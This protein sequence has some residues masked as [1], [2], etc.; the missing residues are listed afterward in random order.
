MDRRS[1]LLSGAAVLAAPFIQTSPARAQAT[2]IRRDVTRLSTSDP[3]FTQYAEAV[4]AMHDLPQ[5][6]PRSWFSQAMIHLDHCPHGSQGF[7]PWHRVY[8]LNFE[9]ICADLIGNPDFA[10]PYW[11]WA[12]NSGRLPG[13]FFGGTNLDVGFWGDDGSQVGT[14]ATSALTPTFGLHDHPAVGSIFFQ[15]QIDL[16]KTQTDFTLFWRQLEGNQHNTVHGVVGA[17][18]GHMGSFLSPLDPCFWLHHCNVD[19]IWAEWQAAGNV[20]PTIGEN[21]VGQF[22]DGAGNSAEFLAD[23]YVPLADLD[24][25]YDSIQLPDILSPFLNE[26]T[27]EALNNLLRQ[28]IRPIGVGEAPAEAVLPNVETSVEVRSAGILDELFAQRFFRPA[29]IFSTQRV[30]VGQRRILARFRD[31]RPTSA[32]NGMI[33]KVFVNCPYLSPVID[34]TDRNYAGAFGFFAVGGSEH[35][36]HHGGDGS[37]FVVDIT[38]PLR[39]QAANGRLDPSGI[40]VQL[41]PAISEIGS[42][43]ASFT[44]SS[45]ELLST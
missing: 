9:A 40:E 30:G 2:R 41:M 16:L 35:L 24:Y 11:N 20:Q 28:E 13:A 34:Y 1:V 42:P 27:D 21:Y 39:D 37:D 44:F 14:S 33:A 17:T 26:P 45:V 25:T 8:L 10:L 31:V 22:V 7:A 12:N 18:G 36:G 6:D 19:R 4:K 43:E 23:Q 32:A 15:R 29:E 38:E 5:S 3:F